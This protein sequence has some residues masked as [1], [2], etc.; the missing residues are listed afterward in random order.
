MPGTAIHLL[1]QVEHIGDKVAG[2][3]VTL[4]IAG[5]R[6]KESGV[7]LLYVG[8][9]VGGMGEVL[10]RLLAGLEVAAQG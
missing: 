8:D 4:G 1:F 6:D 10:L 3:G 7:A 2:I 9:Q 5:G